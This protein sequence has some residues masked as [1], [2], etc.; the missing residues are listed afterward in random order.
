M[1]LSNIRLYFPNISIC[2]FRLLVHTYIRHEKLFTS[3][4]KTDHH[5][6]ECLFLIPELEKLFSASASLARSVNR[7]H[8]FGAA[9]YFSGKNTLI[10]IFSD[11]QGSSV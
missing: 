11:V 8:G 2:G 4:R 10:H 9:E 7:S 5:C 6:S 1:K 3:G